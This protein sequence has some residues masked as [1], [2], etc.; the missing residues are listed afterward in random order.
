MTPKKRYRTYMKAIIIS[1]LAISSL[2]A[3]NNNSTESASAENQIFASIGNAD[4]PEHH[5]SIF[6]AFDR[7]DGSAENYIRASQMLD[8]VGAKPMSQDND[9]AEHWYSLAVSMDASIAEK[10]PSFRGRVKGPAYREHKL[11]AGK[12]DIIREVFYAAEPA[13]L[14]VKTRQGAVTLRVKADDAEILECHMEA[15][16]QA[17]SCSWTPLYTTPHEIMLTNTS[18]SDVFYVLVSN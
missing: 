9:K 11:P 18:D 15:N 14:S 3:C 5:S 8:R 6:A 1:V 16:S 13:Q 7:L 2:N 10:Y 17:R 12:T 4:T